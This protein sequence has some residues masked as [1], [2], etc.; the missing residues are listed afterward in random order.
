MTCLLY[1]GQCGRYGISLLGIMVGD[2]S[3][4]HYLEQNNVHNTFPNIPLVSF[5]F[6]K[7][8]SYELLDF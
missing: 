1:S 2:F 8:Y 4:L 7:M 6:V 5:Q 3:F